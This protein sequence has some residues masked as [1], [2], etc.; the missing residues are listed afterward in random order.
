METAARAIIV[1]ILISAV[2]YFLISLAAVGL[3]TPG[4]VNTT[5]IV[6]LTIT[7]IFNVLAEFLMPSAFNT[8]K[9]TTIATAMNITGNLELNSESR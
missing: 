2:L 6:T 7:I 4:T 1:S 8:P 9:E 3:A 5:S